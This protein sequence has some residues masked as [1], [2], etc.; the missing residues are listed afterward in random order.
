MYQ[1]MFLWFRRCEN[2]CLAVQHVFCTEHGS[3][4][5]EEERQEALG[6]GCEHSSYSRTFVY[7]TVLLT[8][9]S[10]CHRY[11]S[12][13]NGPVKCTCSRPV[14]CVYLHGASWYHRNNIQPESG[15]AEA[16]FIWSLLDLFV[17]F[18][19]AKIMALLFYLVE[20]CR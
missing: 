14:C 16:A 19:S 9:T 10:P 4:A 2:K 1:E 17:A 15:A 13:S 5:W 7:D 8:L 18:H 3:H 6:F 20:K 11:I 12:P